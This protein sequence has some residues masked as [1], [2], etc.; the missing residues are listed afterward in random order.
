MGPRGSSI[1]GNS[2]RGHSQTPDE[3]GGLEM[4]A[5]C[6]LGAA[7]EAWTM[8]PGVLSALTPRTSSVASRRP[9]ACRYCG[10]TYLHRQS[11]FNHVQMHLGKTRCTVCGETL[12]TVITLRNHMRTQHPLNDGEMTAAG[13]G[14][15]SERQAMAAGG[16]PPSERQAM[17]AG[18]GLHYERQAM[19][20]GG[21]PPS[22]RQVPGSCA[23]LSDGS[24]KCRGGGSRAGT[25]GG[26]GR[27]VPPGTDPLACGFCGK[28][29]VHRRTL[30]QHEKMHQGK[31]T[32]TLC[33]E[34]LSTVKSLK[35]HMKSWHPLHGEYIDRGAMCDSSSQDSSWM[36][37]A[38]VGDD[39]SSTTTDVERRTCQLCHKVFRHRE[40]LCNHMEMHRGVTTC[41]RCGKVL[42]TKKNLRL[43]LNRGCGFA[44]AGSGGVGPA[45]SGD[46]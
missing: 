23:V 20:A 40:S 18:D 41:Q 22:E 39:P 30:Y 10:K 8:D 21:G 42:S 6:G 27:P 43:H 26:S 33:G 46:L 17:A 37:G 38:Y 7:E 34:T 2:L 1:G 5:W 45:L 4:H 15:S 24:D 12:S 9:V 29:Y 25:A 36:S 35:N 31:T 28:T 14:S 3:A 32:C 19:A 13:E 16:G 11:L 44:P